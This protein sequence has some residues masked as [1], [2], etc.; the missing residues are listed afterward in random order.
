M[1]RIILAGALSCS[2]TALGA[3]STV[4]AVQ[5]G[6]TSAQVTAAFIA[7]AQLAAVGFCA[8]EPTATAIAALVT[9]NPAL[10]TANAASQLFCQLVTPKV[11]ALQAKRRVAPNAVVD[12]GFATVNGV[13]V[14]LTGRFK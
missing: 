6:G 12:F 5:G 11:A 2:L 14:D 4:S 8:V 9:A 10:T 1:N 3:C 13:K 7:D